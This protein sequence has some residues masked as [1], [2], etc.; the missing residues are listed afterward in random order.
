MYKI[1]V[2][3]YIKSLRIYKKSSRIDFER[4]ELLH[5]AKFMPLIIFCLHNAAIV[6]RFIQ[7]KIKSKGRERERG[8]YVN[9]N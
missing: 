5:K 6:C 3:E 4:P 1:E 2:I 8:H 7:K 9:I